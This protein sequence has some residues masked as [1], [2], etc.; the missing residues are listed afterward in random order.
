VKKIKQMFG[1]RDRSPKRRRGAPRDRRGAEKERAQKEASD[2]KRG[3]NV[4]K[5][6]RT[7]ETDQ[8]QKIQEGE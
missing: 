3:L 6:G 7:G 4:S 2:R 1:K 8:N 5:G